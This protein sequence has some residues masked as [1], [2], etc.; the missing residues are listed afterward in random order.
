ML[1]S[2][3]ARRYRP[4]LPPCFHEWVKYSFDSF[5]NLNF[6][7]HRRH[8]YQA[9]GRVQN[10]SEANEI[11]QDMRDFL[12]SNRIPFTEL[13]AGDTLPTLLLEHL[14]LNW[15]RTPTPQASGD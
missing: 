15:V 8:P 1:S 3:Y 5:N 11:A 14:H 6:F 12:V 4:D 2:Y 7:I 13:E 9:D 10:E